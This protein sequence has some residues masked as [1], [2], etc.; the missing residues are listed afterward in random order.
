[1]GCGLAGSS[2]VSASGSWETCACGVDFAAGASF[3]DECGRLRPPR[4]HGGGQDPHGAWAPRKGGAPA[5]APAVSEAAAAAG[6]PAPAAGSTAAP[7]SASAGEAKEDVEDD[8]DDEDD[9]EARLGENLE[10]QQAETLVALQQLD[11]QTRIPH[12]LVEL[13]SSGYVQVNGKNFGGIFHQ[14]AGFLQEMGCERM[15]SSWRRAAAASSDARFTS[16]RKGG[17]Q[18]TKGA[19]GIFLSKA[20]TGENNMALLSVA[21]AE[22]LTEKCGWS[23]Q[24]ADSGS[25]GAVC[26]I[27]E[28]RLLF[29]KATYAQSHIVAAPHV[30]VELH[31]AGWVQVNGA[32]FAEL[33]AWLARSWRAKRLD[34]DPRVSEHRYSCSGFRRQGPDTNLAARAAE[35]INVMGK[36]A[37]TLVSC[38]AGNVGPKGAQREQRLLFREGAQTQLRY[39]AMPGV[40][41]LVE[42]GAQD[43]VIVELRDEGSA[44]VSG[45]PDGDEVLGVGLDNFMKDGWGC[46]PHYASFWGGSKAL[47]D[48]QYDTPDGFYERRGLL[49]NLGQRTM[50]L[51]EYMASQGWVL[52][53]CS[54]GHTPDAKPGAYVKREQ[55]V[56][57][58]RA[59][60]EDAAAPLFMITLRTLP[61]KFGTYRGFIELIGDDTN[62]VYQRL[63]PFMKRAMLAEV[64]GPQS[65]CE[66]LLSCDCLR[67]HDD[68]AA[69]DRQDH[70]KN[71][72][73]CGES[74]LGRYAVRLC[75]LMVDHIGEWD[76]VVSSGSGVTKIFDLEHEL[77]EEDDEE[78]PDPTRGTQE[79]W[80]GPASPGSTSS[81]SGTARR[82]GRP[83]PW[84]DP[85]PRWRPRWCPPRR[86]WPSGSRRG[87][88]PGAAAASAAC[89]SRLAGG[90]AAATQRSAAGSGG[91]SAAWPPSLSGACGC[92]PP[93]WSCCP[94]WDHDDG[95][96]DDGD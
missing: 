41:R 65:W 53:T 91:G 74:N 55:Q 30:M 80:S 32:H 19:T 21:V 16:L 36:F 49:S 9:L 76:L 54:P 81:S 63:L 47:C 75:D 17:D 6:P 24:L 69:Q 61:T 2:K 10:T 45:L 82:R 31:E 88:P 28:Q 89:S 26:H 84:R 20:S 71:G 40:A 64:M 44:C 37:W 79:T 62:G 14:L 23:L 3:C 18:K 60:M 29:R 42:R 93:P 15:E 34:V 51:A 4:A 73:L 58:T 92:G 67:L 50:E 94:E 56:A 39:T 7:A 38:Q 25:A 13:R 77:D 78:G 22:F 85:P 72:R 86:R 8:D 95:D 68:D 90:A 52:A 66:L 33:E 1:M 27:R 12:L 70:I 5:A 87:P 96:D 83:W 11:S 59:R 43:T 35:L 57:F 46:R 48:L